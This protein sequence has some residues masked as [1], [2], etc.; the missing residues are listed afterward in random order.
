LGWVGWV[1][2]GWSDSK[3]GAAVWPSGNVVDH[4]DEVAQR[5]ARLV[6]RWVTFASNVYGLGMY[7]ATQAVFLQLTVTV[8]VTE[9]CKITE[10]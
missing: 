9:F 8:T 1:G 10:K 4:I 5:R 2:L 6:L 3:G 7:P